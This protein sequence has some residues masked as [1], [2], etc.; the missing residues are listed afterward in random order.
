MSGIN[1]A[2]K[3]LNKFAELSAYKKDEKLFKIYQKSG[4]CL[5]TKSYRAYCKVHNLHRNVV[6]LPQ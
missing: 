4:F 6:R 3:G 1:E 2:I 5:W